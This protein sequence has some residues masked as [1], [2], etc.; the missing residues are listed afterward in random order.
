MLGKPEK[1]E[2]EALILE[3]LAEHYDRH[4]SGALLADGLHLVVRGD[5][6]ALAEGEGADALATV[7]VRTLFTVLCHVTAGSTAL[8]REA[9]EPLAG[10]AAA[11]LAAQ[12]NRI[13][14]R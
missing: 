10:E 2:L 14:A 12:I 8:P 13:F 1:R 11:A 5:G 4:G 6:V 7:P 3:S 9:L